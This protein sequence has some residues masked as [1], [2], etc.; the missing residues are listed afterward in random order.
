M[1]EYKFLGGISILEFCYIFIFSAILFWSVMLSSLYGYKVANYF[2]YGVILLGTFI[3]ALR[4]SVSSRDI[5]L[6]GVKNNE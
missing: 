2:F 5:K 4:I 1:K 6:N 3:S